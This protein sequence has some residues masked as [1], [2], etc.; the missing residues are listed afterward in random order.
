MTTEQPVYMNGGR[1]VRLPARY[2]DMGGGEHDCS[3]G[4]EGG[5]CTIQ[6]PC[7]HYHYRTIRSELHSRRN[8]I[9]TTLQ[10]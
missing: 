1:G 6:S 3:L 9:R 2:G 4:G 8:I 10:C 5:E 7:L